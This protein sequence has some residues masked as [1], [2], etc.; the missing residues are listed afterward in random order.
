MALMRRS[1]RCM[2]ARLTV[3]D[4]QAQLLELYGVE[5]SPS[6]ISTVTD[7]VQEEVKTWQQRP[8]EKVYPIVY[9]D[10]FMKKWSRRYPMVVK[11]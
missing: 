2:C 8:L 11:S 5:V 9:L 4:I 6:L 7:E 3:R 1:L 10:A